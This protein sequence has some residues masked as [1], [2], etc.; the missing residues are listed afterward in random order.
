MAN[1]VEVNQE[2]DLKEIKMVEMGAD[3]ENYLDE[4]FPENLEMEKIYE[5][6]SVS[7]SYEEEEILKD[8]EAQ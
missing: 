2:E 4:L 3:Y 5:R 6:E 8:D 1:Q 7:A